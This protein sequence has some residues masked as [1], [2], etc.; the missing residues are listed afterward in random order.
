MKSKTYFIK[1]TVFPFYHAINI[2]VPNKGEY[3]WP[4]D[5]PPIKP[6]EKKKIRITVED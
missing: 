3:A 6:G 5:F 2:I 1:Y 4:L